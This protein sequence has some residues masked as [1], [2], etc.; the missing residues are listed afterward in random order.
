[1]KKYIS[2]REAAAMTGKSESAIR[3]AAASGRLPVA[4]KAKGRNLYASR[5]VLRR[6][7]RKR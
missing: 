5:D 7:K 6:M 3:A 2:T 4:M 1:M